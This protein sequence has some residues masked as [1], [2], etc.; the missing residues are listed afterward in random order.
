[1]LVSRVAQILA[2]KVRDRIAEHPF[3]SVDL[4]EGVGLALL[5]DQVGR[6]EQQFFS[7]L[8]PFHV[9]LAHQLR[10]EQGV[11]AMAVP[12]EHAAPNPS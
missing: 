11:P 7:F 5:E 8:L 2:L 6:V 12:G 4:V 10:L 9:L 1:M 3:D